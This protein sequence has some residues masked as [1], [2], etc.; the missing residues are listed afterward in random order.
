MLGGIGRT[1]RNFPHADQAQH[2]AP[3]WRPRVRYVPYAHSH[4]STI[5]S[6]A[7]WARPVC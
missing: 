1:G 4:P 2:A 3:A 6:L 5:H 7:S